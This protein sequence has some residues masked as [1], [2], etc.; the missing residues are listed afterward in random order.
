MDGVLANFN[1]AYAERLVKVTG[2]NLL[3][4]PLT[5][6][7][8]DW[9]KFYGYNAQQI[10]DT[11]MSI[12]KDKLFWRKLKPIPE[13]EVFARINVLS[14]SHDVYFLT[15]R[16]GIDCKQQ[17]E[18]FLYDKGIN[19]PTVVIASDKLP[20]LK[21]IKADFFVDDK[22]ETMASVTSGMQAEHLYLVD[23]AY[24]RENR[25]AAIKV[26]TGVKEA[27]EKAGLW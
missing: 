26:V 18:R 2:E 16:F 17:T 12:S 21:A 8:W 7:T 14:K 23:A 15:N 11:I 6:P 24:N 20:I 27:L 25:W 3:P 10:H 5:A 19:Y 9:D 22:L 1:E 13:P 4:K